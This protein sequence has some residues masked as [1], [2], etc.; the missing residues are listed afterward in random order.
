LRSMRR[1]SNERTSGNSSIT[2]LL[3]SARLCRTVPE[4]QRST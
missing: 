3:H 2:F 4:Q 1:T